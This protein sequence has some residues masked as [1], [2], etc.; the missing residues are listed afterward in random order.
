MPKPK[1]AYHEIIMSGQPV[2]FVEGLDYHELVDV[3][4]QRWH[5]AAHRR[6]LRLATRLV[7]EPIPGVIMQSYIPKNGRP[8][9][10]NAPDEIRLG[11][12]KRH[13]YCSRNDCHT[14][15]NGNELRFRVCADH[16]D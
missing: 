16:M 3:F 2:F 15:L 13:L 9:L 11:G 4:K 6:G 5:D 10:P 12:T 1:Y 7:H 8:I 14:R